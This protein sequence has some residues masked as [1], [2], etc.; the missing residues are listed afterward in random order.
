MYDCNTIK[1]ILEYN[2]SIRQLK[3][4]SQELLKYEFFIIHRVCR[5]MTNDDDVFCYVDPLLYQYTINATYLH[6]YDITTRVQLNF[7]HNLN[8]I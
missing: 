5:I 3:Q 6:T 2:G 8:I 1:E 4:L 7:R